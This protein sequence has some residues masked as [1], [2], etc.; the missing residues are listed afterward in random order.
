ML[1]ELSLCLTLVGRRELVSQPMLMLQLNPK[2][3]LDTTLKLIL[4]LMLT[5]MQV[6]DVLELWGLL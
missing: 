5:L 6:V 2:L 4:I 1:A 3:M